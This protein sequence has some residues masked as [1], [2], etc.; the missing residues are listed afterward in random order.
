MHAH[1]SSRD[2]AEHAANPDESTSRP[3]TYMTTASERNNSTSNCF[4]SVEWKCKFAQVKWQRMHAKVEGRAWLYGSLFRR[5]KKVLSPSTQITRLICMANTAIH[6]FAKEEI[7]VWID[8][9]DVMRESGYRLASIWT[10][11]AKILFFF[12]SLKNDYLFIARVCL[13]FFAW[14]L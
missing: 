2:E 14:M 7:H 12:Y 4:C 13:A 6:F 5:K 10:F 8:Y 9:I 11:N 3:I 1:R